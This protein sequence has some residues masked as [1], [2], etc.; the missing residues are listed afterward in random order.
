LF[1]FKDILVF[2]SLNLRTIAGFVISGFLLW[3]TFHQS[4]LQLN[5][6]A[7]H[8]KQWIYFLLSIGIFTTSVWFYALRANLI[9]KGTVKNDNVEGDIYK[10]MLVGNFY[11]C[12]LPGNL[13]D[14]MRGWHF[15]RKQQLPIT[16]S[17]ASIITE[18]WID[19]QIFIVSAFGLYLLMPL[20][21]HYILYSIFLT[22]SVAMVL[23]IIYQVLKRNRSFEKQ[24]WM[25]ILR[26]KKTG[27]V[28]YRLYM[29]TR[30]HLNNLHR[31]K[32]I[33][34]YIF[35]CVSVACLNLTQFF[36]LLK[37]AGVSAPITSLYTSYLVSM[38]MMII[39]FIPAAPGNIGVIHY[40]LYSVLILAATQ[41]GIN[42]SGHDLQHYA[43]FGVYV[44]LSYVIPDVLIGAIVVIIERK[45]LFSINFLRQ[46]DPSTN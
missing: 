5:E 7:L 36:F 13:G 10:S 28:L 26:L 19:A 8:G 18:K 12:L 45:S 24:L 11:N 33:G 9:W 31:N 23:V 43:L 4:G 25:L 44:H 30:I 34:R 40:G 37:A 41:Y 6:L 22:A 17:M 46:V 14:V 1:V 39:A 20:T 3:L 16:K 27:R 38:S 29:H 15:A 42:P 32:Q 35:L 21:S 2:E